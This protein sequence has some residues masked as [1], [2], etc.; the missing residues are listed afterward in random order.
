MNLFWRI[1][2]GEIQISGT[3]A[4]LVPQVPLVPETWFCLYSAPVLGVRAAMWLYS[5]FGHRGCQ[6]IR[7]IWVWFV[8][9]QFTTAWE[10]QRRTFKRTRSFPERNR[11]SYWRLSRTGALFMAHFR[12]QKYLTTN[13]QSRFK[14]LIFFKFVFFC[15]LLEAV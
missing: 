14:D 1:L 3:K 12:E 13:C 6:H 7:T 9:V 8:L 2:N 10:L 5:T 11:N 15:G 4:T